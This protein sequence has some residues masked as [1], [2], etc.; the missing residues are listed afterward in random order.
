VVGDGV[1]ETVASGE[2]EAAALGVGET[3]VSVVVGPQAPNMKVKL[4]IVMSAIK[5]RCMVS[6][7]KFPIINED[8]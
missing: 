6:S 2:G 1:G 5:E 7:P 3:G 4:N 8:C